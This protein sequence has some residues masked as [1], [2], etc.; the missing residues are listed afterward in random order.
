VFAEKKDVLYPKLIPAT[1]EIVRTEGKVTGL[2]LKQGGREMKA[3]TT[4]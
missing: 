2:I 4:Q 1:L 3:T